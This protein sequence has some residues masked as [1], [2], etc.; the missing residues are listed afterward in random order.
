MWVGQFERLGLAGLRV[1]HEQVIRGIGSE[2]AGGAERHARDLGLGAAM[3]GRARQRPHGTVFRGSILVIKVNG[4][5]SLDGD[6]PALDV[7]RHREISDERAAIRSFN[8]R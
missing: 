2:A 8:P 4:A 7:V 1:G 3:T 5:V 6:E